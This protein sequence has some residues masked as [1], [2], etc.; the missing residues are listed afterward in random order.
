MTHFL[1]SSVVHYEIFD[2]YNNGYDLGGKLRVLFD[3]YFIISNNTDS[4]NLSKSILY[5]KIITRQYLNDITLRIGLI[6]RNI[7][8]NINVF[9]LWMVKSII[10]FSAQTGDKE[11]QYKTYLIICCQ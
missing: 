7:P 2:V 6:V 8:I 4:F 3:R 1:H 11:A 9:I 10:F 5:P